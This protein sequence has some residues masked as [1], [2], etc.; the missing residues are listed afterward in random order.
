[1]LTAP[2]RPSGPPDHLALHQPTSSP[3]V[4]DAVLA[5]PSRAGALAG[6]IVAV[7]LITLHVASFDILHQ[8]IVTDIRYFLY[9]AARTA[10]GAVPHRDFFDNKTQLSTLV[11]A[12]LYRAG[13]LVHVDPLYAIRAGYLGFAALTGLFLFAIHR[14][15]AGGRTVPGLI[16]L[17]AYCGFTLLCVL[18]SIGNI[19]KML[20]ALFA[21]AGALAVGRRWW[22]LAGA[23]GTLAFM[24]WQIGALVGLGVGCAALLDSEH[25]VRA[26]A[27]VGCGAALAALPFLVYFA[28]HHAVGAAVAQAI[29]ASLARGSSSLAQETIVHRCLR[30][31]DD[32][33]RTCPGELWLIEIGGI[34]M[35]VYP[36]W[37]RRHFRQATFGMAVALAVYHYGLVAFSAIDF[38]LYGD[39]FILLHSVVFFAAV[40]LIELYSLLEATASRRPA[41]STTR[42]G[43]RVVLV[44][45]ALLAGLVAMVRP[46]F[47]RPEFSLINPVVIRG[48]TLEDQREVAA[49]FRR[50]AVGK[51]LGIVYSSELLFLS[52]LVN[53]LPIVYWNTAVESRFMRQG[54][55]PQDALMRMFRDA[56]VQVIAYPARIDFDSRIAQL[57]TQHDLTSKDG[58]YWA[59]IYAR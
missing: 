50:L 26:T 19:P 9:F 40:A 34:G 17:L 15:L 53:Q 24:D 48:A 41:S 8:P 18:P 52:G 30:I 7:L 20:M 1:M 12:L 3:S 32:L 38:Q 57:F 27:A 49:E 6:T 58:L 10:H 28:A 39:I 59:R 16:A 43:R 25:P 2:A 21:G 56:S 36:F 29:G 4:K 42:H 54:E 44:R 31:I 45:A 51:R 33:Q 55:T 47:L 13:E 46:A 37:L 14:R 23:A 22:L 11:G 35:L 5:S